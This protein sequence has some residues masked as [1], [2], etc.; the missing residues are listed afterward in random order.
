MWVRGE[1]IKMSFFF[2]VFDSLQSGQLTHFFF[3]SFKSNTEMRK[4]PGLILC[5]K[6]IKKES[7]REDV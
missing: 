6:G 1:N 2:I 4:A 7:R 5:F 3:F